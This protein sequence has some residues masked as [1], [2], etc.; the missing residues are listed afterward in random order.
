MLSASF[1]DGN[2]DRIYYYEQAKND[3]YPIVQ[4]TEEEKKMKGFNWQPGRRPASRAAV[5]ELSL[6][7]SERSRYSRVEQPK[8]NQTNIYFPGYIGDIRRQIEV[9]DSLRLVRQREKAVAEQMAAERV[10]L[11]SIARV[12]S[13]AAA[14]SLAAL[15]PVLEDVRVENPD[16]LSVK[17]DSLNVS[18]SVKVLTPAELKAAKKAEREAEKLKKQKE[19]E[20]RWAELDKRDADKAKAKEE[21]RK[22]KE[23]AKKR[24]ALKDMAKQAQKDAE[25][26]EKYR[27]K[28]EK[29]RAREAE[30]AAKKMRRK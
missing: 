20:A 15:K 1:K 22:E 18:D 24:K 16:S 11:D 30:K 9:R 7:P 2:L 21:K 23:R 5:T 8:F 12:D 4:L 28:F 3:G 14:D 25:T 27:L 17:K 26:L 10:R 29:Q 13:L 19:R 6:R